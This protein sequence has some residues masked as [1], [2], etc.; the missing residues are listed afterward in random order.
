[1][2]QYICPTIDMMTLCSSD[3]VAVSIVKNVGTF[4][5]WVENDSSVEDPANMN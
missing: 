5:D 4:V 2:K 3:V 1:M